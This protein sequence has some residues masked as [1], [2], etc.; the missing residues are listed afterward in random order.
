[1]AVVVNPLLSQEAHGKIGGTEF[2]Q[3]RGRSVVGRVSLATPQR[4]L[5]TNSARAGFDHAVKAWRQLTDADRV[6]WAQA[7]GSPELGF[8]LWTQRACLTYAAHQVLPSAQIDLVNPGNVSSSGGA[9]APGPPPEI[10]LEWDIVDCPSSYFMVYWQP[11]QR[12]SPLP[13]PW[14]WL[15]IGTYPLDWEYEHIPTPS[16]ALHYHL[17]CRVLSL[18]SGQIWQDTLW[19][20]LT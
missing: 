16:Y 2:R 12:T 14:R 10:Y 4:T 15:L 3:I 17:R 13:S 18:V 5:H 8:Q 7:A 11:Q 1:M 19:H 20:V 6:L 9:P